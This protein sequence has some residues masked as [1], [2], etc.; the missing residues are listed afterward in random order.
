MSPTLG[1]VPSAAHRRN[2]RSWVGRIGHVESGHP[3]EVRARGTPVDRAGDAARPVTHHNEVVDRTA[4]TLRVR[5]AVGALLRPAGDPPRPSRWAWTADIALAVVIAAAT[6]YAAANP[7]SDRRDPA[8]VI[9]GPSGSVLIPL[10]P[11]LPGPGDDGGVGFGLLLLAAVCTLPLALRRRWP[12]AAFWSVLLLTIAFH[13]AYDTGVSPD[14]TAVFTFAAVLIAGYSAVLY[15]LYRSLALVSLVLGGLL[16]V[17]SYETSVPEIAPGYVPLFV[18]LGIALAANAVHGWKQRLRSAQ[19]SQQASA[20]L[21]VERERA[22]IAREL[23]DVV[24]H[25]V[26]VMVIQAGAAR[27]VLDTAPDRAREVLRSVEASGREAM[28]EL[29]DVIGLLSTSPDEDGVAA[30]NGDGGAAES[31]LT[32]QPGIEQLDSLI[33]RVRDTGLPVDLRVIGAPVPVPAGA[34][35]AAYRV[36]QEGLTNTLKHAGGAHASVTVRYGEREL[37]VDVAD[38]GGMPSAA[39]GSGGGRGLIGL[40]ERLAVYGGSV[41]AGT[42]PGGGFRLSARIPVESG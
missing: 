4:I 41:Q 38:T 26:S 6:L 20:R 9:L 15:S 22:R 2:G 14:Q 42:L 31:L 8:P 21:A 30:A 36:V 19:A 5:A 13:L 25:H 12:L 27:A 39:A 17:A 1:A 33:D 10:P 18:L 24:T 28:T 23:H 29:R 16:I 32:P 34:A 37:A 7:T 11:D 40:R 35:L 3:W